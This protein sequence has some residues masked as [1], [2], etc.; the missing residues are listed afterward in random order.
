[1]V[2]MHISAE[3]IKRC[4]GG[5]NLVDVG[6]VVML[7]PDTIRPSSAN[8]APG[9]PESSLLGAAAGDGCNIC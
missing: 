8:L 5:V 3:F 1:M 2:D 9:E 6:V 7:A 4:R